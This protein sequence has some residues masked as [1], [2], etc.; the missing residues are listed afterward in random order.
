MNRGN[1]L[2]LKCTIGREWYRQVAQT[3]N[4]H[5]LTRLPFISHIF[6]YSIGVFWI[7]PILYLWIWIFHIVL[8]NETI[9]NTTTK[10]LIP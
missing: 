8:G 9:G 1:F 6:N 10:L 3:Y 7:P 5:I 4:V 2:I